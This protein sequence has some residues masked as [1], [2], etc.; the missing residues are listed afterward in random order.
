M[1]YV[2]I[3]KCSNGQP[4]TGCTD[5]LKNRIERHKKGYV[6]A[7]KPIPDFANQVTQGNFYFRMRPNRSLAA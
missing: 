2:Y 4:Y 3:L 7:T 6:P 5:N 1:Y